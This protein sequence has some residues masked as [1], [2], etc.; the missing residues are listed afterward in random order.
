MKKWFFNLHL[1]VTVTSLYLLCAFVT[2]PSSVIAE[3]DF[4]AED[5]GMGDVKLERQDI[6]QMLQMMKQNGMITEDQANSA[7]KELDSKSNGDLEN[8]RNNAIQRINSGNIPTMSNAPK[9][10]SGGK[11]EKKEE[12]VKVNSADNGPLNNSRAPASADTG[13]SKIVNKGS[14]IEGS[15]N[16][17]QEKSDNLNAAKNENLEKNQKMQNALNF[18]N[19]QN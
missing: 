9:M 15:N 5:M 4:A 17:G 7:K 14:S 18:L 1:L 13:A 12:A 11:D 2:G 6:H 10:E 19:S 16:K 8:L 3:D